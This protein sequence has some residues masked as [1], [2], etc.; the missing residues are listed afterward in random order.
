MSSEPLLP[1]TNAPIEQKFIVVRFSDESIHDLELNITGVSESTIDTRWLRKMCRSLRSRETDRRRLRFI[2]NG[3]ILN[4]HSDL[5]NDIIRYFG[6]ESNGDKFY[7]HCMVGSEVLS[8]EQLNNEDALDD[9]GPSSDSTT[10]QAIGFD[11][12]RAV[13]F[14]DEEIEL[15]REQFRRTYGNLQQDNEDNEDGN[16]TQNSTNDIRQ[17]EEQWM[18]TGVNTETGN[19]ITDN[20][21]FNA[22]PIANFK[23]NKDLL[24]GM[25]IGFCFGIFGFLL[26]KIEGL[27]NRRQ[28]MSLIAGIMVNIIFSLMK[29][30]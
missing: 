20:D 5:G 8:L 17:L 15:F 29:S 22:V 4:M 30:F 2:R 19:P 21:N 26:I 13:G 1:T 9:M 14:S 25:C 6:N 7:V 11:R 28:K 27:F 24:I 3:G 12:L 10:T 18:E 16:E 23:H